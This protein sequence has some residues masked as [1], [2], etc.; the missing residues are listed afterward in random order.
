MNGVKVGLGGQLKDSSL[1]LKVVCIGLPGLAKKEKKKKYR[2][3][4]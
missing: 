4:C 2:L 1:F 3:S